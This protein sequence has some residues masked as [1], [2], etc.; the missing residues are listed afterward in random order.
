MKVLLE[1]HAVHVELMDAWQ[2]VLPKLHSTHGKTTI[3]IHS[4]VLCSGTV[5][6]TQYHNVLQAHG[7]C[8][9]WI[10]PYGRFIKPAPC[11][12]FVQLSGPGAHHCSYLIVQMTDMASQIARN[13]YNTHWKC[14]RSV[15][16]PCMKVCTKHH[17]PW[18]RL[19]PEVF[20]PSYMSTCTFLT[21]DS[22]FGLDKPS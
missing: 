8:C 21:S 9:T 2:A 6:D 10:N 7:Y 22:H 13:N 19:C 20:L 16:A 3:S 18:W 1:Q 11:Y 12:L 4:L 17:R 5:S 14:S 15:T